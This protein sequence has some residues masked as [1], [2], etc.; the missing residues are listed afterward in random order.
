MKIVHRFWDLN[1]ECRA[2]ILPALVISAFLVGGMLTTS[3]LTAQTMLSDIAGVV[4]DPSGAAVPGATVT[5]TNESTQA[6]RSAETD[7]TGTYRIQGLLVATYTVEVE[8]QGFRKYAQ[9]NVVVSAALSKRVDV[10]LE[11]GSLTQTVEVRDTVPTIQTES[12]TISASLPSQVREKPI[13]SMSRGALLG[14]QMIYAPGSA[15]GGA[16]IFA[17]NRPDFNQFN[18]EGL[19]YYYIS[20]SFVNTSIDEFSV[21]LS[22]ANAEYARPVTFNASLKSGSN[23]YHAEYVRNFANPVLNA[24]RTPF[25]SP[26][27]RRGPGV[28]S[29]RQFLTASGPIKK[30]KL[31]FFYSWGRPNSFSSYSLGMLQSYPTLT[32]QSGDFSNYPATIIDPTTGDPFP[33]NVIPP[34]R[35]SSVSQAIMADY[36]GNTVNYQGAA[37]NYLNNVQDLA[38]RY[39]QDQDHSIKIDY[40]LGTKDIF[41]GFYS[42]HDVESNLQFNHEVV[43]TTLLLASSAADLVHNWASGL[44]HTHVFSPSVVNQL[45]LGVTRFWY[46]HSQLEDWPG[47]SPILLGPGVVSR[48]GLQGVSTPDLGG[49]PVLNGI[50]KGLS[51]HSD[52]QGTT[53]DT[54][55]MIFDNLS[56]IAGRH[57]IKTGYAATKLLQDGTATGPYF[58]AFNFSNVFS[59]AQVANPGVCDDIVCGDNFADFLLG[60]PISD[61]RYVPRSTIARRKWEYGAFIQD[62][63]RVNSKLTLTYGLR[64]VK[65][66]IPYDKNRMYYNFDPQSQSI[67]VPDQF[68]ADR[69]SPTWPSTPFPVVLA[70][71]VGFPEKLINGSMSW[72]PRIGF[73]YRITPTTVLRGG[74]GLY[75]GASRFAALQTFGPFVRSES[76]TNEVRPGTATGALYAWPNAFPSGAQLAAVSSATGFSKDYKE[77]KTHNYSITLEREL[78]PNWGLQ[79][80]YRGVNNTDQLV[81]RN[82]NAIAPSTTPFSQDRRPYPNLSTINFVE[83]GASSWY[84]SIEGRLTHPWT[85]GLYSTISFTREWSGGIYNAGNFGYT[86]DQSIYFAEDPFSLERDKVARAPW[87]PD[88]DFIANFV[89]ELPVGRGKRFA[90]GSNKILDG[91]I[92]GWTFSGAFSWHSGLPFNP[93]LSGVDFSNTGRFG[94]R[95]DLVSGCDPYS[96]G[97]DVHGMWFNPACYTQPADG[98]NGNVQINS[99]V[100]PGAWVFHLNPYKEFP[101]NFIREGTKL[102]L[103]AN[104]LN[105]FNHPFYARPNATV[106]ATNAGII[107]SNEGAGRGYCCNESGG[108]RKLVVDLRFIF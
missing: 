46:T 21:V 54:R 101:L 62:E 92:G 58:G 84:Q 10:S 42:V 27:A 43:G 77:A 82:L 23:Q 87:W 96:G 81:G 2:G 53:W 102:Q 17:G 14:E 7:V 16:Y 44:T 107:T 85:R 78:Y 83:N 50:Y 29:W 94:G 3:R 73:A 19:Q 69:V 67:V 80:S 32:M 66:T 38:G 22:N 41:S 35:I 98:T 5:V 1:W 33:G 60:L 47:G 90:S 28:T 20:S 31:F 68:A 91:F 74:Y 70:S 71:D 12:A 39:R 26:T 103:G 25:S 18:V 11:V 89:G 99:L 88:Y 13:V 93:A 75:N 49:S 108:Q 106:N 8:A 104:I 61:T 51:L 48:W 56:I 55:Y 24:V 105:I 76:F 59:G 72:Q 40:N 52:P 15:A 45:K 64:W 36:M 57:T 34:D 30:D 37:D 100:G 97:Q 4:S 6:K 9:T 79:V 86:D 63:F 95:P 65:Y